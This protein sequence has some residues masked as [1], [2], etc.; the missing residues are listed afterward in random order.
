MTGGTVE[1]LAV[2][3]GLDFDNGVIQGEIAG[4]PKP[5][6]FAG[7]RG[8]VGQAFR[9]QNDT[10]PYHVSYLR[11]TNG[12]AEGSGPPQ[13]LRPVHLASRVA[14]VPASQENAREV[15]VIR[16]S[17]PDE[18][19]KVR[20]EVRGA[21]ARLYVHDQPQP[22]LIVHDLKTGANAKGAVALWL[23]IGTVAHFRNLTVIREPASQRP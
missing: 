22:T 16:G 21:R 5:G 2:I 11:P 6:A 8:F 7:A 10:R 9:L 14:L 23:D 20:I 1:Q 12:R 18:W 17:R 15:R 19:T 3:D 13:S 4:G